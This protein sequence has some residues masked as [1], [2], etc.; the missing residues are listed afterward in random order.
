MRSADDI[1]QRLLEAEPVAP[2]V[3]GI[4]I[5]AP[6]SV[7][8]SAHPCYCGTI[9]GHAHTGGPDLGAKVLLVHGSVSC[10][11]AR[12]LPLLAAQ[13]DVVTGA[14]KCSPVSGHGG[15]TVGG[16]CKDGRSVVRGDYFVPRRKYARVLHERDFR[17]A[18]LRANS[19]GGAWDLAV[20]GAIGCRYIIDHY[21]TPVLGP[22]APPSSTGGLLRRSG[23]VNTG[24]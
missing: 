17:P 21:L 16:I 11:R 18:H 15:N 7:L 22:G 6:R 3:L 19:G 2:M 24:L 14:W 12:K 8:A 20:H 13:F 4:Q 5:T 10:A 9:T 1:V 23:P